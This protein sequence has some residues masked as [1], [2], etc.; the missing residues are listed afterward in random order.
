M[1]NLLDRVEFGHNRTRKQFREEYGELDDP[2][3]VENLKTLLRSRMLRRMKVR[4]HPIFIR[5]SPI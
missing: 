2:Q 3:Q 4:F 1:F 5:F